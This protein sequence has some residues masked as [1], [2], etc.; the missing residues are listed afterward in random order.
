MLKSKKLIFIILSAVFLFSCGP[1]TVTKTDGKA[2]ASLMSLFFMC[3]SLAK[4]DANVEC[5][6]INLEDYGVVENSGIKLDPNINIQIAIVDK[7]FSAIANHAE[8][9]D[10]FHINSAGKVIPITH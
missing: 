2:M 10:Y 3:Q 7:K 5:T 6:L 8:G 1:Q 4:A 9:K